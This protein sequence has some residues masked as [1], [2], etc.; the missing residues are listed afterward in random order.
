MK[1]ISANSVAIKAVIILCLFLPV[2]AAY[3]Q[4]GEA[5]KRKDSV[6]LEDI[7]VNR[8]P[9]VRDSDLLDAY[10]R[11]MR[12]QTAWQ[13]IYN[14]AY[15]NETTPD[16]YLTIAVRNMAVNTVRLRMYR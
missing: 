9:V 5:R 6:K 12:Y 10:T 8:K 4:D 2:F 7:L 14:E 11:I 15:D 1:K 16:D 3:A 13:D